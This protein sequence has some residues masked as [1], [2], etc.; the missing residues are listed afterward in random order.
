[1][2][3]TNLRISRRLTFV[4]PIV[5]GILALALAGCSTTTAKNE[6]SSHNEPSG[7]WPITMQHQFGETVIPAPAER[8][9]VTGTTDTDVLLALGITPVAFP[10]WISDW[11]RGV[12]PWSLND[13]G[14]A[15]PKL[16]TFRELNFE[17]IAATNPDLILSTGT[18]LTQTDYE[19]LSGLAA[20]VAPVAG[21]TDAYL[22]PWDVRT[23][24]VGEA[25][26][27]KD[28]AQQLVTQAKDAFADAVTEHP[29]WE[30]LTA[31]TVISMNGEFGVYAPTDNRGRFM[32]SLGFGATK[33]AAEITGDEF[34]GAVS[35]ERLDLLDTADVI[36]V[37]EGND[38]AQEAFANSSTFQ[39]LSAVKEGRI[40]EVTDEDTVMAMSAS[41]V[42]SIPYALERLVPEIEKAVQGD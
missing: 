13:L 21:Y 18:Q 16:L 2:H 1:M 34:W 37:L 17:D 29:D 14:S 30:G 39:Q 31:V 28:E 24:Q 32:D 10:Q 15:D 3:P 27:K 25:V 11:E 23:V 5:A 42:T 26:G 33:E 22:V 36:V 9:V 19:K 7:T 35:E 6:T 8:I 4:G 20:T 12:G 38:A 40:V 41:T